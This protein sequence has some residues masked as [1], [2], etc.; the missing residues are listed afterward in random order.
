MTTP[1]WLQEA[2][3]SESVTDIC[4]NGDSDFFADSGDGMKKLAAHWSSDELK[5]WVLEQISLA[6]KSWDARFPFI[7][8]TLLSGHRLHVAFPPLARQGILVSLRR[9]S[10]RASQTS[11][12]NNRWAQSPLFERVRSAVVCGDSVIISGATGSGK[13]TLASDFSPRGHA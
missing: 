11:S 8:A 7:D 3:D 12:G 10:S 5:A 4:L 2:L 9:L 1:S 13:T 6:G